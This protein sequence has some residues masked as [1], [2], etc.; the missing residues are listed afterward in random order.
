MS[1][2]FGLKR[3]KSTL[4]QSEILVAALFIVL[5]SGAVIAQNATN[6]TNLTGNLVLDSEAFENITN[7]TLQKT[8][9]I[10]KTIEI[11]AN[12]QM[13]IF[14]NNTNPYQNETIFIQ[15]NL[16]LDND[17][18]L[19]NQDIEFFLDDILIGSSPT[20]PFGFA[21]LEYDLSGETLGEKTIKSEF[22]GHDYIN[23]FSAEKKIHIKHLNKTEPEIEIKEIE[24]P[25]K[26]NQSES[27]EVKVTITSLY[28][29]SENVTITLSLPH[30]LEGDNLVKFI[31]RIDSDESVVLS[32]K[33][34]ASSCGNFSLFLIVDTGEGSK[35]LESFLMFVKCSPLVQTNYITYDPETDTI[36]IVGNG[37]YCSESNPCSLEDI[38]RA[39]QQNGW[40]RIIKIDHYYS[41]NPRIVFGDGTNETWVTSELE[42]MTIKKPW[43][44]KNNATL[45]FGE[46]IGGIPFRGGLLQTNISRSYELDNNT[47]LLVE[48]GGNLILY[49]TT[50]KVFATTAENNIRIEEGAR[51]V[52]EKLGIQR[53]YNDFK[54]TKII[55]PP[56]IK[57]NNIFLG[58]NVLSE[59]TD[60]RCP[61]IF[62]RLNNVSGKK[63][64]III[65]DA[66][67]QPEEG[68]NWMVR[69]VTSG[70]GDLVINFLNESSSELE[71]LELKCGESEAEYVFNGASVIAEDWGCSEEAMISTMV[72]K[73]G[74][75]LLEFEYAGDKKYAKNTDYSPPCFTWSSTTWT[76]AI[77]N[78][79][80]NNGTCCDTRSTACNFVDYDDSI[81]S[82][83]KLIKVDNYIYNI[84]RTRIGDDVNTTWFET[85]NELI[86]L[87]FWFE[88]R[89][90]GHLISGAFVEGGPQQGSVWNTYNNYSTEQIC[91][92]AKMCARDDG[93]TD[94]VPGGSLYFY[95][96]RYQ[97]Y[98]STERNNIDAGS[99]ATGID[100]GGNG[101]QYVEIRMLTVQ[102][103]FKHYNYVIVYLPGNSS[104]SDYAFFN[105]RYGIEISGIAEK[106]WDV[107]NIHDACAGVR[108]CYA[109][110]KVKNYVSY[111]SDLDIRIGYHNLYVIDSQINE[112]LLYGNSQCPD[113]YQD[114]WDACGSGVSP[115][116]TINDRW[117]MLQNTYNVKILDITGQPI[118]NATVIG[119]DVRGDLVFNNLTYANG[120]IDEKVMNY[121]KYWND[122]T[123]DPSTPVYLERAGY[124]PH[125]IDYK[126]Y[127]KVFVKSISIFDEPRSLTQQLLDNN[128]INMTESEAKAQTGIIYAPPLNV[129]YS[130]NE[131]ETVS[132]GQ[133]TLDNS[134]I[135]QSEYL[136]LFDES[137]P[138]E[139]TYTYQESKLISSTNY[140][141]NYETGVVNISSGYNGKMVRVVYY[142]GGNI[143]ITENKTLS[144]VYDYM[145]ANL[146]DT[147]TTSTGTTYISYVDFIL[148]NSSNEGRVVETDDR[149]LNIK[150]GYGFSA[151]SGN[152][153]TVNILSDTWNFT[154]FSDNGTFFRKY[155]LDVTVQDPNGDPIENATV[156]LTDVNGNT[157]FVINTSS[158]GTIPQQ[159]V[160]YALY[161]YT[162]N[163]T[164]SPFTLRVT[165]DPYTPY[166]A[167]LDLD[168]KTSLT[169][170]MSIPCNPDLNYEY[171]VLSGHDVNTNR[172]ATAGNLTM[173]VLVKYGEDFTQTD[174]QEPGETQKKA[175]GPSETFKEFFDGFEDGLTSNWT[176]IG[177]PGTYNRTTAETSA[178]TMSPRTDSYFLR[179]D[180][181]TDNNQETNILKTNYSF[182]GASNII[183][184]FYH[185]ET[186]DENTA[187]S[188]HSG[189]DSD[190]DGYFFTCGGNYWYALGNLVDP[191]GWT[192]ANVNI[193]ADPDFCSEVNSSFAIKITQYDNYACTNDGR[194]FDDINIS[195]ILSTPGDTEATTGW[196]TYNDTSSEEI[197]NI[198][199]I[200]VIINISIYNNSGSAAAGNNDPDLQLEIYNGSTWI[201]IGNFSVSGTGNVS[202]WT[203]ESTILT[204]W[205]TA[206]N[207]D[208]RIR[209]VNFDYYNASNI[210][211]INWTDVWVN[212]T[213]GGNVVEEGKSVKL[214]ITKV[215]SGAG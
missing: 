112:S 183:L 199:N 95:D 105:G 91:D 134:P 115:G 42:Q 172:S 69:F 132:S 51:T 90:R 70:T 114:A 9:E 74:T 18:A 151:A 24:F 111:N 215:G 45:K 40:N 122:S 14:V 7:D 15:T 37:T 52:L 44:I 84:P 145:Q 2:K 202:L 157:V 165:K 73:K 58:F 206:A 177:D 92:Q 191:S 21:N 129:N 178:C 180:V 136:A 102:R 63:Q 54:I 164:F 53:A 120:T 87:D 80:G 133:I 213:Y 62:R 20:N 201:E 187:C 148:G 19:R 109:N 101:T 25:A 66:H 60:D 146:S 205:E 135:P 97:V 82:S 71:F 16:N 10:T 193:S 116:G 194:Y 89:E 138:I 34:Q 126:K 99:T 212:I 188:D 13:N 77:V 141:V 75:H 26:V 12:S 163:E 119:R 55:H 103:A 211:E 174:D 106:P 173:V 197:S 93:S 153:T 139:D 110:G 108:V 125:K 176:V 35:Y 96:S 171:E 210:D 107:L 128:Y 147:F 6:I 65:L 17:S 4:G 209:G 3:M 29:T 166:S 149:T 170:T 48:P 168:R 175:Q 162:G 142:Y 158:D 38:Y 143:T 179:M 118:E 11:Y 104:V 50:Y 72:L 8:I 155:T 28:A 159:E 98:S 200:T 76:T 5:V 161:N 190:C 31:P 140:T 100:S 88:V 214:Y 150:D 61:D 185:E 78:I 94:G 59:C 186:G 57:V 182:T 81:P 196:T 121:R 127:G 22:Q 27:F 41:F 169:V 79:T 160:T 30:G 36:T 67:R 85:H 181:D 86:R 137:L 189:D 208:L 32:W 198:K 123:S 203:N 195:Y 207:R 1:R 124:T 192:N 131:S 43:I 83:L 154:W 68:E 113:S 39:D 156:N 56:S 117:I 33:V 23:P 184:D 204:A 144:N 47:A 64:G 130:S 46:L 167:P 152:G 49:D